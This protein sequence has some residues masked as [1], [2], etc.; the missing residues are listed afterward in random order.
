MLIQIKVAGLRAEDAS[1]L[2]QKP[3]GNKDMMG[4]RWPADVDQDQSMGRRLE[5]QQ[6]SAS[7]SGF[8]DLDQVESTTSGENPAR[9]F[10]SER[11]VVIRA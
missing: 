7:I 5:R 11:F 8:V 10:T 2:G 6:S 9:P 4:R 3:A 1:L